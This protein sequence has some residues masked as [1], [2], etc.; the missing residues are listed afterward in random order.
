MKYWK[1][2]DGIATIEATLILPIFMAFILAFISFANLALIEMRMQYAVNQTA[3]EISQYY[4]MAYKF[5]LAYD[6]VEGNEAIDNWLDSLN[7]LNETG[8][9][10]GSAVQSINFDEITLK[11][12]GDMNLED[13][14]GLANSLKSS[15]DGDD[16]ITL[17]K[18]LVSA[19]QDVLT[20]AK[21]ISSGDVEEEVVNTAGAVL[22]TL[23]APPICKALF[24][25]YISGDST[26]KTLSAWMIEDG[27]EGL[28][29]SASSFLLDG[30]TIKVTVTYKV[31]LFTL[32]F[33]T[34]EKEMCQVA[35]TR[36][37]IGDSK[38][39]ISYTGYKEE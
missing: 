18:A 1:K 10:V 5:G 27:F 13:L 28:D 2:E 21:E 39:I 37:W 4:Y 3:K 8:S 26:D 22:S 7:T 24:P 16:P 29:F 20:A 23:I 30:Q 15:F 25:K 36:A 32:G 31:D 12:N 19:G 6:G 17:I 34:F 9:N 11:L 33:W 38:D 14:Q 35:A